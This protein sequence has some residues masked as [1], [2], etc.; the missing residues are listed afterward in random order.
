MPI[1]RS[2]GVQY[3][4]FYIANN[5]LKQS[6]DG[7]WKFP[8]AK[9]KFDSTVW[10]CT[11]FIVVPYLIVLLLLLSQSNGVHGTLIAPYN[12][13]SDLVDNYPNHTVSDKTIVLEEGSGWL[14]CN[15]NVQRLGPYKI[16]NAN[17][18]YSYVGD[19]NIHGMDNSVI[20]LDGEKGNLVTGMPVAIFSLII[21]PFGIIA[22]LI[23][24]LMGKGSFQGLQLPWW[25]TLT[26]I[27]I[28]QLVFFQQG[29]DSICFTIAFFIFAIIILWYLVKM[30][31][32]YIKPIS[33]KLKLPL[34]Y[35][36]VGILLLIIN[37]YYSILRGPIAP[38]TYLDSAESIN[39][40]G[41]YL[42]S[43]IAIIPLTWGLILVY[44]LYR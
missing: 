24:N 22:W 38:F 31:R 36:L 6:K 34:L 27:L 15:G 37:I 8:R 21:V 4:L 12:T 29:L 16:E 1:R 30:K 5:D 20:V 25:G 17:L 14:F 40:Y 26:A 41:G 11:L 3:G 33:D 18:S 7:V 2:N 32:E 19:R 10:A 39:F 23:Q 13:A 35:L 43:I 44:H 9:S 28:T 42:G